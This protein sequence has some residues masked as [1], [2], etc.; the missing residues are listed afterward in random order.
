MTHSL[1]PDPANPK[2]LRL[3]NH[4]PAAI[5]A[6]L[7]EPGERAALGVA[8]DNFA[9]IEAVEA[10]SHGNARYIG[11]RLARKKSEKSC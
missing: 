6:R 1:R 11:V 5:Q 2:L 10:E 3:P 7:Y 8:L 9:I 4:V